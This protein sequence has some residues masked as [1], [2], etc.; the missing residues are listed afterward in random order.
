MIKTA[1][2]R[3]EGQVL[4]KEKRCPEKNCLQ[5]DDQIDPPVIFQY[6][7]PLLDTVFDS[8]AKI[9]PHPAFV[10]ELFSVE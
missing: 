1:L 10:P 7:Q 3:G 5:K 4:S 6:N 9:I 8:F 2:S